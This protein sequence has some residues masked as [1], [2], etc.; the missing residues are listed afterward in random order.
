MRNWQTLCSGPHYIKVL[1]Q[2]STGIRLPQNDRRIA[3]S[4]HR[5]SAVLWCGRGFLLTWVV[6][7]ARIAGSWSGGR[8]AIL[9]IWKW[10]TLS[11]GKCKTSSRDLAIVAV[12]TFYVQQRYRHEQ[13]SFRRS[14]NRSAD[15]NHASQ[16]MISGQSRAGSMV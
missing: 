7:K 3:S 12:V 8:P 5:K 15:R 13:E 6:G 14:A 10:Y 16:T 4:L 11:G 9:H 2:S 1:K